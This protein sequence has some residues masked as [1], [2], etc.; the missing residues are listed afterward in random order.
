[1]RRSQA[2]DKNSLILDHVLGAIDDIRK[3]FKLPEPHFRLEHIESVE[4]TRKA[5][6]VII[7]ATKGK[8][9]PEIYS[10]GHILL[11]SPATQ[12]LQRR[13]K[14]LSPREKV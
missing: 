7:E 3:Q 1:M 6:D 4:G 5:L 14:K 11:A 13:K 9:G 2:K 8:H 12:S 10:K